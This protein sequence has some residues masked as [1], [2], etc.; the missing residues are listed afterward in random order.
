MQVLEWQAHVERL[1][2]RM[3]V[4]LI[5]N[6]NTVD[7]GKIYDLFSC[8]EF[9]KDHGTSMKVK[10]DGSLVPEKKHRDEYGLWKCL[11]SFVSGK[12]E[13]KSTGSEGRTM[14][15]LKTSIK[16]RSLGKITLTSAYVD[17]VRKEAIAALFLTKEQEKQIRNKGIQVRIIPRE[18]TDNGEMYI[19]YHTKEVF[20]EIVSM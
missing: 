3:E 15:T 7:L 11:W 13:T 19:C 20:E 5:N 9:V 18:H 1:D 2:S 17:G 10:R 6:Q 4:L 12:K 8:S 16:T 14:F